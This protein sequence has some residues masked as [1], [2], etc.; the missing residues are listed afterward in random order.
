V[1]ARIHEC[2]DDIATCLWQDG[3]FFGSPEGQLS[4]DGRISSLHAGFQRIVRA[5]PPDLRI[6]P[7][8][9]SYDFMT[10]ARRHVFVAFAPALAYAPKLSSAELA[11]RLRRSWLQ[12]ASFTCTQLASGYLLACRTDSR[13]EF[14]LADLSYA[15]YQQACTLVAAGRAVDPRLLRLS[16]ATKRARSYLAYV[17]R[18]GLIACVAPNR[19]RIAF[20]ELTIDIGPR[21][22]A[23]DDVPLLYAY[24]ELQDL[25]SVS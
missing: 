4:P 15:I 5:A 23:Y 21:E 1:A 7:I 19:W 22:V 25:L 10:S 11:S 8:S 2:L 13:T 14:T 9:L 16:S 20:T 24:N 18:R 6:V 12:H 3:S 17:E